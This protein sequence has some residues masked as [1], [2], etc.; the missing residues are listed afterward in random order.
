[1]L[2]KIEPV[3]PNKSDS[4]WFFN[5]FVSNAWPLDTVTFKFAH[6][7]MGRVRNGHS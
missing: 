6:V 1:M 4:T 3:G 5:M 2:L 7:G